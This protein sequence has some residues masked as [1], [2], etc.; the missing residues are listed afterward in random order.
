M[1]RATGKAT[2]RGDAVLTGGLG[3]EKMYSHNSAYYPST[4]L[5]T[6]VC[7][8]RSSAS[9]S[10]PSPPNGLMRFGCEPGGS[11]LSL[12]PYRAI[13]FII[14]THTCTYTT[15]V[16]VRVVVVVAEADTYTRVKTK[17]RRKV[18][19]SGRARIAP[20]Q[21]SSSLPPPPYYP[22]P[23]GCGC[24]DGG[25]GNGRTVPHVSSKLA[26]SRGGAG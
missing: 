1:Y 7:S 13:S 18:R 14:H 9:Y 12:A 5:C 8:V 22:S 21:R 24:A 3:H 26:S 2:G 10:F 6:G 19:V 15:T 16:S 17:Y 11:R 25:G 23:V 4:V 20:L